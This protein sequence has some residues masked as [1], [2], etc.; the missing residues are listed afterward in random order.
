MRSGWEGGLQGRAAA[1]G[2]GG[3]WTAEQRRCAGTR[4][5][6]NPRHGG[7]ALSS[8]A[9]GHRLVVAPLP[10]LRGGERVDDQALARPR[11]VRR[12]VQL[13]PGVGY[14]V[15]VRLLVLLRRRELAPGGERLRVGA[16]LPPH[17]RRGDRERAEGGEQRR[18]PRA[19]APHRRRWLPKP[20]FEGPCMATWH[21]IM[22]LIRF[23]ICKEKDTEL[24]CKSA[25]AKYAATVQRTIC[26]RGLRNIQ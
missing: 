16:E 2:L 19:A 11:A 21:Y 7:F 1:V 25:G 8:L 15:D 14:R 6:C 9:V 13:A 3:P 4:A 5:C 12:R 10:L 18:G 22:D 26:L 20:V 24:R 23:G 17:L